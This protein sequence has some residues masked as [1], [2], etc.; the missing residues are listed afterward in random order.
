VKIVTLTPKDA[1][2]PDK[3]RHIPD[4]PKQLFVMGN[5]EPLNDKTA[6]AVVGSRKVTTY[7]RQIT[8]AL[9]REVASKGVA[10]IS[11]LALGVDGLAHEAALEVGAYTVAVLPSSLDKIS[12][13]AHHQLA[14]RILASGGALISEYPAGSTPLLVNFVARNRLVSGLSNGLLITEAAERS[15]TL[16]TANFALEQGRD[17][18]AVPGNIISPMSKGTNK[19]IR[20]GATVV[21]DSADI[22]HGLGIDEQQ[23]LAEVLGANRE[24]T[25]LLD[26]LANG[27][28][29]AALLLA[30]SRLDARIFNQTLTM[31]EISGKIRPLGSGHWSIS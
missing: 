25:L 20:T 16:H 23:V 3:L 21:T 13:P 24:E 27:T 28:S 18:F 15:G 10:I 26:L 30:E 4:P 6:L 1:A 7:G 11:G 29:D 2:F 8:L 5:L 31:L 12:P 19:L 9:V 22:L 14:Q 17:V